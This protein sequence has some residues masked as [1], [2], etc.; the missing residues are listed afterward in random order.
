MDELINAINSLTIDIGSSGDI[1][2]LKIGDTD[3]FGF[4]GAPY[5][6]DSVHWFR[7]ALGLFIY[8][9]TILTVISSVGDI[10]NGKYKIVKDGATDAP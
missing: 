8:G 5:T 2:Y 1:P 4:L 10:I 9:W 7:D 3:L 6:L